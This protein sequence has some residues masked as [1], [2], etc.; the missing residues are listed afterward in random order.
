[1][2]VERK[3]VKVFPGAFLFGIIRKLATIE[4]VAGEVPAEQV[5]VTLIYGADLQLLFLAG[6]MRVVLK[7]ELANES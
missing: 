5:T 4:A 7:A 1:M 6:E 2:P 3:L